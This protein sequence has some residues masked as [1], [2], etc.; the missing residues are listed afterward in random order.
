MNHLFLVG[1][2]DGNYRIVTTHNQSQN[3]LLE[4]QL[5]VQRPYADNEGK[6]GEDLLKV[7][8]WSN[9]LKHPEEDLIDQ[10]VVCIKGRINSFPYVNKKGETCYYP[11]IMAERLTNIA[12]I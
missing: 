11:E 7:K 9:S 4:F 6:H 10:E 5:R 8:M 2:I 1:A 3:R 12:L